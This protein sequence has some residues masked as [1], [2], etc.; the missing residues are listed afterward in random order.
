MRLKIINFTEINHNELE[1]HLNLEFFLTLNFR[2]LPPLI[3][4][5]V[6]SM[7]RLDFN[8]DDTIEVK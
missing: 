1:A 2:G 4:R 3:E 6:R 8:K 7:L 5:R